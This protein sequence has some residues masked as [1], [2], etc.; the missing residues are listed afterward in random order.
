MTR[1][2]GPG[3]SPVRRPCAPACLGTVADVDAAGLEQGPDAAALR[4]GV[5]AV[6]VLHDVDV[7][8]GPLGVVLPGAPSVWVSWDECRTALDEADPE[9]L[10]GRRRLLARLQ[11]RRWAA[12]AGPAVLRAALVPAGLPVGHALHPGR[13]WVREHVLGGAL[14]LG[15]AATGLDPDDPD[16]VV[17]L[18]QP[19][20]VAAGLDADA[21]WPAART[22]LEQLGE[23]AAERLRADAGGVLRPCGPC[24][25]VSLLGAR[26]LRAALAA[27]SGGMAAAVVPMRRRGWTRLARV[28]TAFGPAAAAATDVADRGFPR[29]L[30]VTLDEVTVVAEGGRTTI[31]LQD[32]VASDPWARDVLY[33]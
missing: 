13:D 20:L 9:S 25:V 27:C 23:V 14:D 30:L 26:S 18:P 29:P 11:A 32:P 31:A 1:E 17:L 3:V 4:R 24:D 5:L 12:D 8:P 28:D 15:L 2:R 33:R 16:A 6:S 7:E 21:C 10:P 19:A 22:R